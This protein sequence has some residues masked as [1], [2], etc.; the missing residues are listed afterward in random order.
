[1]ADSYHFNTS[2]AREVLPGTTILPDGAV[3]SVVLRS[4]N[5]CGLI[6]YHLPE[7]TEVRIP[8]TDEFRCGSLYSVKVEGLK[9]SEWAYRYYRDD[10]TFEDPYAREL[11]RVT[12]KDLE[13]TIE[14]TLCRLFPYPEAALKEA[15]ALP[16]LQWEN[17]LIYCLHV[18]GFTASRSSKVR[19]RGSFAGVTEKIPHLKELGVTAVELLPVYE[20]RPESEQRARYRLLAAA[21]QE[22]EKPNFWNF[23]E[24]CYFAPKAAYSSGDRPAEEFAAMV[25][26]L[27][28]AGI[29]VF[30]QLYFPN[31]VSIHTRLETARFYVTRY[32]VDGFHLKGDD[33]A[34]K[35]IASD[36][37][38]SDT[39]LLYYGFP[40]EELQVVDSE[41]PASGV[42]SIYHLAEYNDSYEYLLRR[43]VKSDDLIMQEF[44]REFL[45]VKRGHGA[46]RYVT[47]YE[48]FTLMD[49]VS[50]NRKH[51]ELNGEDNRDGNDHNFSWNCGVEGKSRKLQVRSLR[52]RQIKN[53]LLLLMLSQGTP[54][55]LAGDELENSQDGNNNPYCQD[56]ETGWVNWKANEDSREILEFTKR[57]S[58]FR[59][60]H[61]VFRRSKPFLM[62]D[63][64]GAGYPDVSLHG[65][66]AWKPDLG[67]YSHTIG[68]CYYE[69]EGRLLYLAVNMYWHPQELGLPTPPAGTKWQI[70]ADTFETGAFLTVDPKESHQIMVRGRSIQI[71]STVPDPDSAKRSKQ[72]RKKDNSSHAADA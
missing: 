43:F 62:S 33:A 23:G 35:A 53:F 8:F 25:D 37:I 14:L 69:G 4:S 57:I 51:N 38:L 15:P 48:G 5:A 6:L 12:K 45:S 28:D 47:N 66:E 65:R 31:T 16:P 2:Y 18:K 9:P 68:I 56:N 67:G 52:Q 34:L 32:R 29:R 63:N 21:E 44:M 27:H 17:E 13:Q 10:L 26:A 39:A 1:M 64:V 71:L 36:P 54:L 46:I 60:E 55:L 24:G 72:V 7:L 11:I 61:E 42:P 50:Y 30:L 58:A 70:I 20:L 19:R 59:R 40:Y 41:N 22:I 3:F 49:L